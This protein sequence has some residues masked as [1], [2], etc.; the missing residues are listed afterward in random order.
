MHF[1]NCYCDYEE[2]KALKPI[3]TTNQIPFELLNQAVF[4]SFAAYLSKYATQFCS[5]DRPLIAFKTADAYF[6]AVKNYYIQVVY[7]NQSVS[8][9]FE[10]ERWCTLRAKLAS[11][12]KNR[13]FNSKQNLVNAQKPSNEDDAKT[14]GHLCLWDKTIGSMTFLLLNITMVQVG[15]RG[16]EVAKLTFQ[17]ISTRSFK[18]DMST[19]PLLTLDIVRAKTYKEQCCDMFTYAD[20]DTWWEDFAFV[21][22]ITLVI[23]SATGQLGNQSLFPKFSAAAEKEDAKG[24]KASEVAS[25]W[26]A[27]FKKIY[28]L[29]ETFNK[30]F[31]DGSLSQNMHSYHAKKRTA[32]SLAD[33][34]ASGMAIIFRIGWEVS[35]Q[36]LLVNICC[37]VYPTFCVLRKFCFHNFFYKLGSSFIF[38]INM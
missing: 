17:N 9:V 4:G 12:M 18:A 3:K 29:Y 31:E 16:A 25:L 5:T 22:G 34:G 14:M 1:L 27:V 7:A 26:T 38:V 20:V 21:L 11:E 15:G 35:K 19:G 23:R 36:L 24:N 33:S 30:C 10:K 32:Q 13:A 37:F 2:V 8:P 6:S 28:V